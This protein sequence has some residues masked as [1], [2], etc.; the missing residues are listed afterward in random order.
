MW[1][2]NMMDTDRLRGAVEALLVTDPECLDGGE[3]TAVVAAASELR[4]WLDAFD[5]RCARRS[6]ERDGTAAGVVA[7]YRRAT[8]R[9]GRCDGHRT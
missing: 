4:G 9:Q 1:R 6:R 5:V 3:L 7:R 8:L 2:M